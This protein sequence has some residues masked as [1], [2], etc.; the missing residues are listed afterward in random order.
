MK[1]IFL[2]TFFL[3]LFT[4]CSSTRVIPGQSDFEKKLNKINYLGSRNASEVYL[5]N[6]TRFNTS[7]LNISNDSLIFTN[8]EN[9]SSY[10]FSVRQLSR[11]VVEDNT[12]AILSGLLI[13][14]GTSSLVVWIA[15]RFAAR[16]PGLGQVVIGSLIAV[17]GYI[18]GYNIMGKKEFIFNN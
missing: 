11:I 9:D 14:I 2:Y 7:F 17:V 12:A 3:L 18:Y 5:T 15:T 16:E 1:K 4:S 10:K 8:S 6:G 13:G